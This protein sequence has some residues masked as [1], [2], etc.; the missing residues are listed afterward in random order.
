MFALK[1]S[2]TG[3]SKYLALLS[4]VI[5]IGI[6]LSVL[7]P[8]LYDPHV[9]QD[10][11]RQTNYWFSRFW[12]SS[13][14]PNDFFADNFQNVFLITPLYAYL[15]KSMPLF[16]GDMIF[17][18]KFYTVILSGLSSVAAFLF[19]NKLSKEQNSFL[20]IAFVLAMT[21]VFW[22]TDFLPAAHVRSSLWLII[23]L[24]MW[25]KESNRHL[26]AGLLL[27]PTLFFNPTAFVICMGMEGF[28]WILQVREKFFNTTFFVMAFN[29]LVTVFYHFVVNQGIRYAGD[30]KALTGAEMRAL[31]EFNAG[32]RSAVFGNAWGD[33]SWW[34]NENWGIGV[35]YLPISKIII[36]AGVL[37]LIYLLVIRPNWAF[38]KEYFRS[39]PFLLFYSSLTL[40]FLAKAVFPLLYFPSRYVGASS[41]I[42]STLIS[43]L[44]VEKFSK[45][46]CKKAAGQKAVKLVNAV[47]VLAGISFW[48]YFKDF[49]HP[50][51]VSVTPVINNYVSTLPKD[52]LIAGHPMIPDL[53]ILYATAKRKVFVDLERSISYTKKS[54]LEIRRR[55]IVSLD[56]VY[57]KSKDDFLRLA[58]ENGI[59]HFLAVDYCYA[60]QYLQQPRY[61]KPFLQHLSKI[62]QLKKGESFFVQEVLKS[63][64]ANYALLE[65]A[66]LAK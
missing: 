51:F 19:I 21:V 6:A 30:G 16:L 49:Y 3:K 45:V 29:T 24:Y 36:I 56:M 59:T 26:S 34:F 47:L 4:L 14:F 66:N 58:K 42:L 27:L 50:R 35:G 48:L 44:L 11:F 53:N 60:P 23:F 31:P 40:F 57:A 8:D 5:G 32:G 9:I 13:L 2:S 12:D 55:N 25:L 65:I 7:G 64:K 28:S 62:T 17:A 52:I 20:S 1:P 18:S 22:C 38:L 10:D 15:W 46:I 37:A 54:I 63:K 61:I 43:F 33:L 39:S 41:L